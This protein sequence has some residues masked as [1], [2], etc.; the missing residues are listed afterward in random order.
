MENKIA[1]FL[2]FALF[3]STHLIFSQSI[4]L[5]KVSKEELQEKYYPLDSSANAAI[6]YKKRRTY[7]DY[8]GDTG[9]TLFTKVKERIKI[10]NKEGYDW[11]TKRINL[12][13]GGVDE[14]VSIKGTTYS[15]INNKV[16]K[17]KLKSSAIFNEN[18]NENWSQTKFTM[19]NL[20]EGSIV[21]WEYTI[22]STYYGNI[23]VITFQHK[24]PVK[25]IDAEIKIPE[26]FQFKYIPNYFY[27]VTVNESKNARTLNF[28]YRTKK[29]LNA[30]GGVG[31]KTSTY[32]T[33]ID[34][35]ERVYAS[36]EKNIPA[37]Q[38]EPYTNNID[39]YRS[40][41]AFELMAYRPKNDTPKFFNSSWTDVSIGINKS[42]SFGSQLA[43][44]KHYVDDLASIIDENDTSNE[45]IIKAF[46]FVKNKIKWNGNQNKYTVDGVQKAYENGVGN[47]A[48]INLSLVSIL[49]YLNINSSPILVSTRGNGVPLFPTSQGYNYVIAGIEMDNG[50]LILLDATEKYSAPNVLPLRVLNWQGQIIRKDGTSNSVN[51]FPKK[52]S[53]KSIFLNAK[54]DDQA[55][56]TGSSRAMYTNLIALNY[57]NNYNG[58]SKEDL[59]G[60]LEKENQNIEISGLRV[61]NENNIGKSL[62]HMLAFESESHAEIIGSKI[63]F[64]PLLFLSKKENP[65][66]LEK[67][68]YPVDFGAPFEEKYTISINIPDGYSIESKPENEAFAL[69]DDMGLYKFVAILNNNKLQVLSTF[70]I[71]TAIISPNDYGLLK[72]FYK[73]IIN[74]QLEKV[75]L[76]K[77]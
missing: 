55:L 10:Y 39:N 15:L 21:E 4:K 25:Y 18:L 56:I 60:I 64:S 20:T 46:Q 74:K 52:S 27:P 48:E 58:V 44:T 70:Q 26:F 71:N 77:I 23:D 61:S 24:I 72:D 49:R 1:P 40:Q 3:F 29:D 65:F 63:Y 62:M 14:K 47:A 59:I 50:E 17:S 73:K 13:R 7:Y 75:V 57:R 38:E 66:K 51:L 6:V 35:F 43:K 37:L 5:N 30:P 33:D 22:R 19:P 9:W 45:K 68:T 41:V 42:Q 11:A 54:I 67:R 2:L 31:G 76:S 28:T 16:E 34:I 8:N 36:V 32:N 53:T 12:Y 69:P